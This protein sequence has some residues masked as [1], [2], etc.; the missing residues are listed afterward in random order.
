MAHRAC[1]EFISKGNYSHVLIIEDDARF[2]PGF[3]EEVKTARAYISKNWQIVHWH[4]SCGWNL[5]TS[6][7]CRLG[8]NLSETGREHVKDQIYMNTK[9]KEYAGA[10]AYELH[11][12]SAKQLLKITT[13]V[14]CGADG[15]TSK[16]GYAPYLDYV[17]MSGN[18]DVMND[19]S[20]IDQMGLRYYKRGKQNKN[21]K[22]W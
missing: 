14:K 21:R 17:S 2:K 10:S 1:Y 13:P 20:V 9:M 22:F 6:G 19:G 16:F 4:T 18:I 5:L 8:R 11:S 12:E 3:L 7:G 15:P